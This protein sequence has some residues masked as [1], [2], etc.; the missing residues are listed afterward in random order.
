MRYRSCSQGCC[1]LSFNAGVVPP[2]IGR[3][4]TNIQPEVD[5]IPEGFGGGPL[6]PK[7]IDHVLQVGGLGPG[8]HLC[9]LLPPEEV[10]PGLQRCLQL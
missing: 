5:D 4:P 1:K 7:R 3:Y 2:S 6:A 9:G 8:Q 10:M